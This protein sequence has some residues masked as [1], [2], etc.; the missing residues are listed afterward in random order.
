MGRNARH[1]PEPEVVVVIVP[2]ELLVKL[3][4]VVAMVK[5]WHKLAKVIPECKVLIPNNH[6]TVQFYVSNITLRE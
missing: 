2:A 5:P 4:L 3:P 6:P 1:W